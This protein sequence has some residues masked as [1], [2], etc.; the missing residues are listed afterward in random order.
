MQYAPTQ[1]HL[2]HPSIQYAYRGR[3]VM[4]TPHNHPARD[5]W[6]D[7]KYENVHPFPLEMI[8]GR[9][10]NA[11]TQA[12]LY[13]PS[14]QYAYPCR[15]QK[16]TPH[17]HSTR[18]ECIDLKSKN[19]HPFPL[20]MIGWRMKNASTQA[21]LCIKSLI[22]QNNGQFIV[23]E[24][25]VVSDNT[26]YLIKVFINVSDNNKFMRYYLLLIET[27]INNYTI[28]L[29]S[30]EIIFNSWNRYLLLSETTENL[31]HRCA[32]LSETI[33]GLGYMCAHV[34]AYCI[35]PSIIPNENKQSFW[36][37]WSIRSSLVECLC[38]VCN[39]PIHGYMY[40][41]DGW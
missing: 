2:Y 33:E 40:F 15:S 28:Y 23:Q 26:K 8:G 13:H 21:H 34:G 5:E 20:E 27:M 16:H 37:S 29:L 4:L 18:D 7:L 32:P 12:H 11:Y 6:I 38:G 35:R 1:A 9:M 14:I 19:V 22:V 36:G 39:T 41:I 30:I 10:K 17:K 25:T 31:R 24:K 3:G